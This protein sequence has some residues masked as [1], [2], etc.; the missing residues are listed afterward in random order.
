VHRNLLLDLFKRMVNYEGREDLSSHNLKGFI[1]LYSVR[2]FYVSL[3]T[4]KQLKILDRLI[5]Y[6]DSSV[7]HLDTTGTVSAN[8]PKEFSQK[9]QFYYAMVVRLMD[10]T[11]ASVL[12]ILFIS[13][14][15]SVVTISTVLHHFF[16]T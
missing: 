15:H 11:D 12:P 3:F 4:V 7:L 10:S 8:L 1:Q 6:S 2:P 13:N 5:K 9:S 14:N 16:S